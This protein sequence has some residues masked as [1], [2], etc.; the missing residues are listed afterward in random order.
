[1]ERLECTRPAIGSRS[2]GTC[3]ARPSSASISA[4]STSTPRESAPAA[5]STWTAPRGRVPRASI[6]LA[7][8]APTP[9]ALEGRSSR[10]PLLKSGV[11]DQRGGWAAGADCPRPWSA[12]R[13]AA[14]PGGGG[15][16]PR[17][18]LPCP[19]PSDRAAPARSC[20][21]RHRRGRGPSGQLLCSFLCDRQHEKTGSSFHH[22]DLI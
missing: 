15:G 19:G 18:A 9:R 6:A 10:R 4:S 14:A 21:L 3:C 13:G 20:T 16:A 11:T 1:M 2:G 8:P 12:S 22:I 7:A 17:H 5:G